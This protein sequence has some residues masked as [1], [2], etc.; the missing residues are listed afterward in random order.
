M[1]GADE[2]TLRFYRAKRRG[3]CG[4]RDH[5]APRSAGRFLA[6]LAAGCHHSRTRMR[7]RRRSAEMLARGFDVSATDGSPEMAEIASRRLGRPVGTLLFGDIR[8]SRPTTGSRPMPACCTCPAIE[9]GDILALIWRALKPGGDFY[10]SYKAGDAEGRDTLNRYY[11]YPSPDWLRATMP[12]RKVEL[13][14]RSRAAR[15]GAST[16]NWRRCCLSWP[17]RAFDAGS[18]PAGEER[19]RSLKP[20]KQHYRRIG[21]VAIGQI[22]W[23]GAGRPSCRRRPAGRRRP[24]NGHLGGVRRQLDLL[25]GHGLVGPLLARPFTRFGARRV[26][27]TG[28]VV[29]VPG[30]I[31]LSLSTVRCCFS[32]TGILG[33]AGS[34]TLATAAY[35]LF[36]EIAGRGAKA[37]DRRHD[38]GDGTVPA[39]SSGRRLRFLPEHSAGAAPVLSMPAMLI[40]VCVPLVHLR[41]AA[42]G[43]T[44]G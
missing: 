32:P 9:L 38:A 30:F 25:R 20:G 22:I 2:E 27:I 13:H 14:W 19:R 28:T 6:L 33:S 23:W 12:G 44:E 36:N 3:L 7:R 16:T 34:A 29:A 4:A 40:L 42:P 26:M 1:E 39:A 24:S 31:L 18:D 17:G 37:R 11:N 43:G 21:V 35:I 41:A 10:A 15:S 8:E 5:L